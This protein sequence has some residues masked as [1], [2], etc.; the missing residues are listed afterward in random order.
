MHGLFFILF[1]PIL[2]ILIIINI[3]FLHSNTKNI[4][5]L[6]TH[7]L[8][9]LILS[10]FCIIVFKI[11]FSFHDEIESSEIGSL[12]PIISFSLIFILV[13]NYFYI[14]KLKTNYNKEYTP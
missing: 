2:I 11:I 1:I 8:L 10:T 14:K 6:K 5:S 7:T 12:E 4:I 3:A 13:A 9:S